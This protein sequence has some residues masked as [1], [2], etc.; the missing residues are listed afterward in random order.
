M[1]GHAHIGLRRE[2]GNQGAIEPIRVATAKPRS[3]AARKPWLAPK[4]ASATTTG[5]IAAGMAWLR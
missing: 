5:E 1:S 4:M 3:I 2:H